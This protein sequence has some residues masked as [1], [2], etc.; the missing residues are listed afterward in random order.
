MA[1][2]IQPN[3]FVN[4]TGLEGSAVRDAYAQLPAPSTLIEGGPNAWAFGVFL[5]RFR[6]NR[7]DMSQEEKDNSIILLLVLKHIAIPDAPVEF[8]QI[9]V[10][11]PRK[12]PNDAPAKHML[13]LPIA[14]E[15]INLLIQDPAP[16]STMEELRTRM[17]GKFRPGSWLI[18]D[19]GLAAAFRGDV[20]L[21][22]GGVPVARRPGST[23][24]ELLRVSGR[25]HWMLEGVQVHHSRNMR[26]I[27]QSEVDWKVGEGN[28]A[29]L[30]VCQ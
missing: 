12:I 21:K 28:T 19:L 18:G 15:T 11:D 7:T 1:A 13:G 4:R 16:S 25:S 24:P 14:Y 2:P 29:E 22:N 27:L 6:D 30:V 26:E 23:L 8:F 20:P 5:T 10:P 9:S 3:E 17:G